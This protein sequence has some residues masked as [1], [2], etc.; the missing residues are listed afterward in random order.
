[1][2][3]KQLFHYFNGSHT[4]ITDDQP[5]FIIIKNQGNQ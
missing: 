4:H 1:M 5:T 2:E 3:G